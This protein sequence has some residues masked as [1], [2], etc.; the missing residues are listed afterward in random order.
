[1]SLRASTKLLVVL[2]SQYVKNILFSQH[3][4]KTASLL[5]YV[6][7]RPLQFKMKMTT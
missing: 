3:V 5:H 2:F 7:N 6:G 4:K 1:M